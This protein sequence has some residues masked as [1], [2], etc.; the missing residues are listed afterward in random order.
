MAKGSRCPACGELTFHQRVG[1]CICSN[2]D[3]NA[4]GWIREPKWPGSGKGATCGACGGLRV[5]QIHDSAKM[6][7]HRCFECGTTY[8]IEK[9]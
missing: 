6:S 8:V 2:K 3:C 4:V 9:Q 5:R 1:V 7:I